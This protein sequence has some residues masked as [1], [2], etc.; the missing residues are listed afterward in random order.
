MIFLHEYCV[1][2]ALHVCRQ[3]LILV[4]SKS[5]VSFLPVQHSASKSEALLKLS[6]T[7]V[8]IE[9]ATCK[10][11]SNVRDSTSTC[12]SR[13]TC[14]GISGPFLFIRALD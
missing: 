6:L 2:Y 10:E 7:T 3:S 11:G 12:S 8:M 9:L 1:Q 14:A 4:E 5:V 13:S